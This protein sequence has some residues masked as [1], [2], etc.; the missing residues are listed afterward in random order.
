MKSGN[1]NFSSAQIDPTQLT[2]IKK[3][4]F[5]VGKILKQS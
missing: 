5:E 2:D 1:Q 3:S 4:L